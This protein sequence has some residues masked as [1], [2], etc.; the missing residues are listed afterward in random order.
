M[1]VWVWVL[2]YTILGTNPEHGVISKYT[3]Q[4]ECQQTLAAMREERR[5]R[6]GQQI[7]GTC[8]QV[9]KPAAPNK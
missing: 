3:S 1:S 8:T 6:T 7:V 9:L 2:S 4:A 5:A